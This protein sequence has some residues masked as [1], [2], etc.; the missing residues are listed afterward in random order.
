MHTSLDGWRVEHLL[1][2]CCCGMWT[3]EFDQ[4]LLLLLL[5]LLLV[6]EVVGL[7]C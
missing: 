2:H 7:I 6:A 5:L 4:P 3:A 1:W